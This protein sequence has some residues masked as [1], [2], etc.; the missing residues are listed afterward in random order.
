[1]IECVTSSEEI[2]L[3]V[4]VAFPH[5]VLEVVSRKL[6]KLRT[7]PPGASIHIRYEKDEETMSWLEDREEARV[8]QTINWIE[9]AKLYLE[10][11]GGDPTY[12]RAIQDTVYDLG[13][14]MSTQDFEAAVYRMYGDRL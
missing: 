10:Q 12:T 14:S 1:M 7:L 8:R 5:M 9:E 11:T 13:H 6:G 4:P 2:E 3:V